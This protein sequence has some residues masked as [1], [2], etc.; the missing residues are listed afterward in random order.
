MG[1]K[2][3]EKDK[4][5]F[6]KL[7]PESKTIIS[8]YGHEF[9]FILRPISHKFSK[10]GNDFKRRISLLS[11]EEL[12]YIVELIL[13]DKEELCSLEEEDIFSFL[14]IVE[15]KLSLEKKNKIKDH[16]SIL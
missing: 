7:A 1:H 6:L 9:P 8:D 11:K 2:F 12:N 4:K 3:S 15:K 16:L 5:I 10:D 13:C 14:D